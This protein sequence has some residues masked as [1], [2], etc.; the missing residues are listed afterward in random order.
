VEVGTSGGLT[1][2]HP[3]QNRRFVQEGPDV[4]AME[5]APLETMPNGSFTS[6]NVH[7][8]IYDFGE[9]TLDVRY[10]RDGPDAIYRYWDVPASEWQ[11]LKLANSKGSYINANVAFDY[12]YAL[13]G[14]DDFPDRHAIGSDFLRRFVYDP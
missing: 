7:S 11:G 6:S 12:T 13:F 2:R 14:R 1:I 5:R 10:L 4:E 8:A 9:R 3:E